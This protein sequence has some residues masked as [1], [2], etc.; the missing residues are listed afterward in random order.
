MFIE[1]WNGI[2][3]LRCQALSHPDRELRSDASGSWGAGTF[4]NS[5]WIQFQWPYAFQQEQIAIKELAQSL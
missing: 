5:D 4:W 1:S 3:I 2:S